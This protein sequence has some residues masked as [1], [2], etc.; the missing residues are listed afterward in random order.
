MSICECIKYIFF[1]YRR[2]AKHSVKPLAVSSLVS[3]NHVYY[4]LACAFECF[5]VGDKDNILYLLILV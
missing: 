1:N 4:K 5:S 3:N 2:T